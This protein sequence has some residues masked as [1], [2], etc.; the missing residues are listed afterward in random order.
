M[1]KTLILIGYLLYAVAALPDG[2]PALV[3]IDNSGFEDYSGTAFTDWTAVGI[4]GDPKLEEFDTWMGYGALLIDEGTAGDHYLKTTFAHSVLEEDRNYLLSIKIETIYPDD[5]TPAGGTAVQ[6][7][8]KNGD[9]LASTTAIKETSEWSYYF[10]PFTAE[11][12]SGDYEI[13][14]GLFNAKGKARFDEIRLLRYYGALYN[15]DFEAL[16]VGSVMGWSAAGGASVSI[17]PVKLTGETTVKITSDGPGYIMQDVPLSTDWSPGS[18][19]GYREYEL[20][21]WF[22]PIT[23]DES[24]L[25]VEHTGFSKSENFSAGLNKWGKAAMRFFANADTG[26]A[27]VK[28]G[29]YSQSNGREMYFDGAALKPLVIS[30]GAFDTQLGS[31][32]PWTKNEETGGSVSIIG[33]QTPYLRITAT[34]AGDNRADQET[35]LMKGWSYRVTGRFN[36]TG[37]TPAPET[38]GGAFVR[39]KGDGEVLCEIELPDSTTGW[40]DMEAYFTVPPVLLDEADAVDGIITLSLYDATGTADFD[41][42]DSE[43]VLLE[44]EQE[45]ATVVPQPRFVTRDGFNTIPI[46]ESEGWVVRYP[47]QML[48]PNE[49]KTAAERF[50][51]ELMT[52]FDVALPSPVVYT[53]Q[54]PDEKVIVI[55]DADGSNQTFLDLLDDLG[56][57]SATAMENL[58]G[59]ELIINED[60]VVVAASEPAGA[61]YGLETLLQYLKEIPTRK[62]QEDVDPYANRYARVPCGRIIDWPDYEWRAANIQWFRTEPFRLEAAPPGSSN[63]RLIHHDTGANSVETDGKLLMAY[64]DH[65]KFLASIKINRLYVETGY[66]LLDTTAPTPGDL[67][68]VDDFA[69]YRLELEGYGFPYPAPPG[70]YKAYHYIAA[71]F[72]MARGYHIEPIPS[73]G[74]NHHAQSQGRLEYFPTAVE[75]QYIGLDFVVEAF[76]SIGPQK[77]EEGNV[78]LSQPYILA[79]DFVI[80]TPDGQEFQDVEEGIWMR[81]NIVVEGFVDEDWVELTEGAHYELDYVEIAFDKSYEYPWGWHLRGPPFEGDYKNARIRSKTYE[82]PVRLYYNHVFLS[83]GER[84]YNISPC[85]VEYKVYIENLFD[86]IFEHLRPINYVFIGMGE[87]FY[88]YC[89]GR[90]R[91]YDFDDGNDWG[92]SSHGLYNAEL[93]LMSVWFNYD[94]IQAKAT[95]YGNPTPVRV[96]LWDDPVCRTHDWIKNH[97]LTEKNDGAWGG[98]GG[99]ISAPVRNHPYSN[100]YD[101]AIKYL[102]DD[103][104]IEAWNF[105]VEQLY[106]EDDVVYY[107]DEETETLKFDLDQTWWT[108]YRYIREIIRGDYYDCAE[109]EAKDDEDHHTRQYDVVFRTSHYG[110]YQGPR[111]GCYDLYQKGDLPIFYHH[112][113]L[114]TGLT[115]A[116]EFDV[117]PTP[118]GGNPTRESKKRTEGSYYGVPWK[119]YYEIFDEDRPGAD[120]YQWEYGWRD[121]YDR[122][123]Y[124]GN[125]GPSDDVDATFYL[126]YYSACR[127]ARPGNKEG[128]D[129]FPDPEPVW[130]FQNHPNS[131]Q[132]GGGGGKAWFDLGIFGEDGN[133]LLFLN[134]G[135]NQGFEKT[136]DPEIYWTLNEEGEGTLTSTGSGV[137]EIHY[138]YPDPS[139]HSY[140]AEK[141]DTPTENVRLKLSHDTIED[142]TDPLEYPDYTPGGKFIV[143]GRLRTKYVDCLRLVPSWQW[144]ACA[145]RVEKDFPYQEH[146]GHGR[147]LG[148]VN[149]TMNLKPF[150]YCDSTRVQWKYRVADLT[151]A[152]WSWTS[153]KPMVYD[154]PDTTDVKQREDLLETPLL[155]TLWYRPF[156][157][158]ESGTVRHEKKYVNEEP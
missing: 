9:R 60:L 108:K 96:T 81:S 111:Y 74:G 51:E 80:K 7:W 104:I 122:F 31:P 131:R 4:T 8:E 56:G 70:G 10:V 135:N 27:T 66:Y 19:H 26:T 17:A 34:T 59:Y 121:L 75:G 154:D 101:A 71:M 103:T 76:G 22:K 13:R 38:D 11:L 125:W 144:F 120:E 48:M 46:S 140:R 113:S 141:M 45:Y 28:L 50:K 62:D 32:Y 149:E 105:S 67:G 90:S 29:V 64:M 148:M 40:T 41:G 78:Y 145:R 20:S 16:D 92:L 143:G 137:C 93:Y 110:H 124:P 106:D 95:D 72:N 133:R 63:Y 151:C 152:E 39:V 139:Y 6:I 49:W 37:V 43:P 130:F 23:D 86:K 84:R 94:T 83:G 69:E 36:T 2:Y 68:L 73:A 52:E 155:R 107:T 55:G 150:P 61:Q 44:G 126:R 53:T 157:V 89:D 30:D 65:I 138:P 156:F 85:A 98:G 97:P 112:N 134:E 123:D 136:P 42:F 128:D 129:V 99:D 127:H 118:L 18:I 1:R 58:E 12:S 158:L 115:V 14:V 109:V 79:G 153:T 132:G 82:G 21:T 102:P 142:I 77:Y 54:L 114:K 5:Y 116:V 35:V 57:V 47:Y 15:P 88:S 24:Q 117:N 25:K 146:E 87:I 119:Q 100:E 91:D 33:G 147:V 3:S